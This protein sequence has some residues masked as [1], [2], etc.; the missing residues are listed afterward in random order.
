VAAS[1][2]SPTLFIIA[3]DLQK[4]QVDTSIAEADVGK[5]QADMLTTFAVDA[6]PAERF[7]GRIRQIRNAPQTVQNVVTYDAVID[8]NNA[9]LKLRPGMTANVTV[10]Y[11]ERDNVLKVPN[12][13]LRFRPPPNLVPEPRVARQNPDSGPSGP[14]R[15]RG[16]FMAAMAAEGYGSPAQLAGDRRVVWVLRDDRPER[17]PLRIGVTDGTVTEVVEG[18]I[19]EGDLVVT[20]L[21]AGDSTR[22]PNAGGPPGAPFR[23]M[24]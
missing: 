12:A 24:F 20:D 18:D 15:K 11:A 5:L 1:L 23:R 4:M 21:V 16:E 8:V 17:V 6:Y 10:V 2:Q 7:S 22:P 3:E 19:H 13:A 14:G 9:D